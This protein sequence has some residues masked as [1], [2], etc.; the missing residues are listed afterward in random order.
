GIFEEQGLE[1]LEKWEKEGVSFLL[2]ADKKKI[3]DETNAA[4]STPIDL[5][6]PIAS[7]K[8]K[9]GEKTQYSDLFDF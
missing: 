6:A 3:I 1:M 4:K 7:A 9:P 5:D 2:G 8:H